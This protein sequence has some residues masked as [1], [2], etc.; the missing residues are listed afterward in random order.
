[1]SIVPSVV[2]KI[3]SSIQTVQSPTSRSVYIMHF[4]DFFF[5]FFGHHFI[6]VE[7]TMGQL[8]M[9]MSQDFGSYFSFKEVECHCTE[10]VYIHHKTMPNYLFVIYFH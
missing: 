3:N 9:F 8:K 5:F 1:M 6:F 4:I 2:I 7:D 10:I